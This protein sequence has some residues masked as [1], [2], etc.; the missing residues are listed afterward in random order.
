MID[1]YVNE[2]LDFELDDTGDGRIVD[3]TEYFEQTL[4][5]RAIVLYS[6][7]IGDRNLDIIVSKIASE[8]QRLARITGEIERIASISVEESDENP[9]TIDVNVFYEGTDEFNETVGI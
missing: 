9:N 8:A 1:L 6:E 2:E 3:S 5:I 4:R 7:M